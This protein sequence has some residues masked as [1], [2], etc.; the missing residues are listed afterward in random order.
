MPYGLVFCT[1]YPLQI[2]FKVRN[3]L[4]RIILPTESHP[5]LTFYLVY[6]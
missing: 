6:F 1:D 4:F 2:S 5:L 3:N